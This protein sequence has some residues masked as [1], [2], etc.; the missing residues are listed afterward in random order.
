MVTVRG[1]GRFVVQPEHGAY[2]MGSDGTD[3]WMAR[4]NG[5]VCVASDYRTLAPELQRQIPNRR[6]LNDILTSPE[7][8][9]LLG[10]SDLLLLIEQRYDI[11]LS[12]STNSTVHRVRAT[13]RSDVRGRA[14]VINFEVDV[15]SGVVLKAELSF[16]DSRQLSFKL[17]ETP[18]RSDEW[19]H[20][21]AHAP[22]RQVERLNAVE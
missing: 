16:R 21:S 6:L 17:I 11:E 15:K 1:G 14:S 22:D 20:Y 13:R 8:Q 5:P 7:E 4:R 2:T 3:Y 10:M 19:Y 9:L 18:I 12:D